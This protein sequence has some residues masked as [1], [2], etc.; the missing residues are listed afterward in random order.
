MDNI[1]Q[2][3]I[4]QAMQHQQEQ[5]KGL[6]LTNYEYCMA[7]FV[8]FFIIACFFGKTSNESLAMKW[9]NANK[10]F[11]TYNYAH[12]GHENNYSNFNLSS[13]FLVDSYSNFKFYASGRVN[14]NYMLVNIELKKRQDL[15]SSVS[16]LLMSGEK[17]KIIYETSLSPADNIPMVFCICKKKDKKTL[18]KTYSDIDFFTQNY[19][20]LSMR[21]EGVIIL[22]ENKEIF[23]D[24]FFANKDFKKLY[25]KVENF[26][27]IIFFTDRQTFSKEKHSIFF[28]FEFNSGS[29]NLEEDYSNINEFVHLFIDILC[30]KLR[31]SNSQINQ[32]VKLRGEY[33]KI[34]E[35]ENLEKIMRKIDK[36]SMKKWRKF[37]KINLSLSF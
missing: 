11:Y 7:G 35:K 32:S 30:S 8:L 2:E 1:D 9:F 28:S 20:N 18:M 27:D 37:N 10:S 22:T 13:P 3:I 17:D 29:E 12:I 31:F 6:N 23:D 14:V 21:N 26:I 19:S 36:R 15:I 16:S 34:K 5:D 4:E 33:F 24:N 25:N